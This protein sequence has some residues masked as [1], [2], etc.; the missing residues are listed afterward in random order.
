MNWTRV[1]E[2]VVASSY[3]VTD[4]DVDTLKR[5]GV[6]L[7]LNLHEQPHDA[8]RL[9][10]VEIRERHIPVRDFGAPSQRQIDDAVAAIAAAV[11]ASQGVAVHCAYGVG[12]TGTILACW[13][14]SAG[15]SADESIARIR[16]L[17]PGSVEV[18]PQEQAVRAYAERIRAED[19]DKL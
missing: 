5:E 9:E 6:S 13:F 1:D 2:H 12:R 16:K 15:M 8:A 19:G 3:P 14:V 17:R 4:E 18:P 10:R 7:L 11:R